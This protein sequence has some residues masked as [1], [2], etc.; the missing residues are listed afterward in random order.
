MVEKCAAL[1]PVCL[2]VFGCAAQRDEEEHMG[3]KKKVGKAG[4]FRG[5]VVTQDS[6]PSHTGSEVI[7]PLNSRERQ[8]DKHTTNGH[9][10]PVKQTTTCSQSDNLT[11]FKMSF[12]YDNTNIHLN[13]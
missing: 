4:M 7:H 13:P 5:V 8:R 10:G 12:T 2:S 3:F 11:T 1:T 9:P 6:E